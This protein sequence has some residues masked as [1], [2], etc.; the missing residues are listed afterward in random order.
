[1][2]TDKERAELLELMRILIHH[3]PQVH[4]IQE[5]PMRTVKLSRHEVL[6][7]LHNGGNIAMD[8]S[9]AVTCLCKWAGLHD[10]N[11]RDFNGTGNTDTIYSHLHRYSQ[12]WK[13]KVGALVVFGSY[14]HTHHVCMVAE[15]GHDPLLWSHG[16]ERGPIWIPLHEEMKYQPRGVTFCSIAKL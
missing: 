13:A 7:K 12:P 3:E 10:P 4:Y 16:Q 11:G 14:P 15:P 6:Q 1:M 2:A 8:C 5:R 9:E